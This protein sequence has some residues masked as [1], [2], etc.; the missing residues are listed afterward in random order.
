MPYNRYILTFIVSM[1]CHSYLLGQPTLLPT[2]TAGQIITHK[3][4]TLSYSENDKQPYWVAYLLTGSMLN[5]SVKRTNYF[6]PDPQV[7]TG[8]AELSD[9]K[10]SGY[11]RGHLCPAR[12]MTFDSEAMSETFYLSN[13]SPQVPSFNRGVWQQLEG[14]VRKWAINEDSIFVVT[15]GIMT[16]PIGTIGTNEVTAPSEFY[17]IVLDLTGERKMIAFI[18]PNQKGKKSFMDY[19]VSVDSV[20]SVT[21]IDFFYNLPDSVEYILEGTI[22]KSL[23]GF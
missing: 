1:L 21:G 10:R 5:G 6:R 12:D 2:S 8:S 18:L 9:Y 3:Y 20:E 23:W 22:D 17:K 19:A 11:N 7:T 14:M 4:Y 15:G 13:M 16:S